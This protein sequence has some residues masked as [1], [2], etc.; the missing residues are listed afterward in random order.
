M[1]TE[2][3]RKTELIVGDG[4]RL[5]DAMQNETTCGNWL[6]RVR[7]SGNAKPV[8]TCPQGQSAYVAYGRYGT[9][10]ATEQSITN[11]AAE[12]STLGVS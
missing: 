7:E 6:P 8:N 2:R 4:L 10:C 9:N 5:T 3:P 11:V 12:R 1:S